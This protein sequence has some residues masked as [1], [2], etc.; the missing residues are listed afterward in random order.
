[1]GNK[2]QQRVERLTRSKLFAKKKRKIAISAIRAIH[3]LALRP[4]DEPEI[5]SEFLIAATELDSHWTQFKSEDES[6]LEHLIN[7]DK[8]EDYSVDMPTEVRSLI[9]ASRSVVEKLTP[10][11]AEVIDLSYLKGRLTSSGVSRITN[12]S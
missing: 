4:L 6:V 1:M 11:G 2:E 12:R 8:S 5:V 10:K 7:L 9:N 3:A